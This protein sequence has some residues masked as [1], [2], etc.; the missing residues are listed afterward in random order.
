MANL[1]D[2]D[3]ILRMFQQQQLGDNVD[4][5]IVSGDQRVLVHSLLVRCSTPYLKLLLTPDCMC[6]S[7]SGL[8]LSSQYESILP[9]FVSFLY[10]GFTDSM[11]DYEVSNLI[12]L[13]R[14]LGFVDIEENTMESIDKST[15]T[16][17]ILSESEVSRISVLKVKTKLENQTLGQSFDFSLPKSRINRNFSKH[18]VSPLFDGFKDRVQKE[19]NVCPVGAYVGPYD[20]NEKLELSVQLPNS[21][22]DYEQ[23]SEFV[24]AVN[25]PCGELSILKNYH[26][27]DDLEK[28]DSLETI[29][30]Q[31]QSEDDYDE[32]E[33]DDHGSK[34]YYTCTKRKCKIPCICF[35]CSSEKKECKLHPIKHLE[36]FD[37]EK[38]AIAIRSSEEFC[39][40]EAFFSSSYILRYSGIPT[41][42]QECRRDLIHHKAYHIAFHDSCKFCL[43]NWFKLRAQSKHD[44]EKHTKTEED[45]Q[46]SVCPYCNKRF[47]EPY[48]AKKH[49]EYAHGTASYS[50][51]N[52]SKSF[53][54][55]QALK[56]HEDTQHSNLCESHKCNVCEKAFKSF[57]ALQNHLKF[58]HNEERK[59]CC[60]SCSS[61]FKQKKHLR[62]HYLRVHGI[63]Q[64][65][66]KYHQEEESAEFSCEQC[67]SI[68][69][70]RKD[71]N[72]HIRLQH[73]KEDEAK[74]F[75]CK[76]C[77]ANYIHKKSLLDH[78]KLKHGKE[79]KT[80]VCPECG[81]KF[82]LKKTLNR[83]LLQ[84]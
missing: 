46:T 80:F 59:H 15:K 72:S 2:S 43:Q 51:K 70:Y 79:T 55:K 67:D 17:N 25:M 52:C 47:C 49:I 38:D 57:V 7:P 68:F 62:E 36:L 31:L 37:E 4:F 9:N 3:F 13:T 73:K 10:T 1:Q 35:L 33:D 74:T 82:N 16:G 26:Q 44:L 11:T 20:Q 23:Y 66:E 29:K 56:Y 21:N 77:S 8:I 58:V 63:N 40:E 84:H 64:Y 5:S 83:H 69:H 81:N 45:Y 28:I 12:S 60:K 48:F 22:L 24:H 50:C 78:V 30:E 65:R 34:E 42:C 14:E 61:K 76:Q 53:Q 41:S 6:N 27:I 39:M 54:S 18:T 71:L 19:Y 75:A 32:S